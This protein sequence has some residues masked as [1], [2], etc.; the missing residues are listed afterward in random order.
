M[1]IKKSDQQ[2]VINKIHNVDCEKVIPRKGDP[3]DSTK[4]RVTVPG[5]CRDKL[6]IN[7]GSSRVTVVCPLNCLI[8]MGYCR[9]I[10]FLT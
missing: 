5:Y 2:K 6:G 3:K 1:L 4:V 8:R 10:D 7:L 9:K